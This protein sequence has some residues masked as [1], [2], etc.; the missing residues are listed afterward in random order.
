MKSEKQHSLENFSVRE[1]GTARR[2]GAEFSVISKPLEKFRRVLND[3]ACHP[4][5]PF[6]M[7]RPVVLV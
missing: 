7:I 1:A 5:K 4:G 6:K 3:N 2:S